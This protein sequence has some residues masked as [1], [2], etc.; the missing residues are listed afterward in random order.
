V[1]KRDVKREANKGGVPLGKVSG[2]T[3]L[4]HLS[5]DGRKKLLCRAKKGG[6]FGKK[7]EEVLGEMRK[8]GEGGRLNFNCLERTERRKK[9]VGGGEGL[10]KED[11]FAR[12]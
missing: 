3:Y 2:K 8:R 11:G 9:R 10:K 12:L 4:H 5:A 7:G 6:Q 1:H